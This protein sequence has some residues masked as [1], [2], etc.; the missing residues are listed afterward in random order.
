MLP[1][2]PASRGAKVALEAA[3]SK[4]RGPRRALD[5]GC[6]ATPPPSLQEGEPAA[7]DVPALQGT[8]V[9]LVDAP[10]A[11]LAVPG[12]QGKGGEGDPPAQKLPALQGR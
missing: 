9:A 3:P 1:P 10:M 8:H 11:L 4:A 5:C 7:A 6:E 2:P 12:G